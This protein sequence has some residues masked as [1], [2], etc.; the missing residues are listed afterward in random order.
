M[1]T[2][3]LILFQVMLLSILTFNCRLNAQINILPGPDVTP[4]DMVEC[5]VGD[6]IA[7]DNVTFQGA[8]ASRGIFTN[9][10]A[11][12]I[13]MESGIFLTSGA[14]YVIPGPNSSASAGAN[15][16][17]PGH[18]SL[19]A[20]TTAT[21]YDAAVLEF[22]FVPESDTLRFK[23]VFGSEEYNEWVFTQFNDVFG[24]FVS[25][26]D[27]M[28]GLYSDKN[29]AIVPGTPNTSVTINNVNNGYSPPGVVPIGPC[30]HCEYYSDNTNGISLEYDGF[31]VVLIAWVHVVA[32]ETYH[33]KIGVADAGDHIYDSGVFIEENSFESPKIEVEIE[34]IPQGVA[35]NMIEGCVEADIIFKLPNA[36]YAPITVYFEV[37]GSATNGVDYEE[38]PDHITFEEGEDTAYIHVIPFKDGIIEGEEDIVI[39]IENTLGCVVRYDTVEFIIIDYID[40]VTTPSPNTMICDG[41]EVEIWVTTENGIPP[42]TY[43]WFDLPFTTD[44]ITVSPDT[45]TTYVVNVMD[46]CLD[47]V[48]DSVLVTV[49]PSP[50]I[51]LGPDSVM[52]CMGDTLILNAG[53]GYLGYLWQ[54]GS[55]DSTYMV[56]QTGNYAVLVT[57]PGG[58]TGSDEIYVEVSE[59]YVN[60]GPDTTICIGDTLI[61]DAGSGYSSYLWQDNSTGQVYFATETGY[62]WVEV[63]NEDG[64]AAIDSLY[65]YVDDSVISLELGN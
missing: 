61:L 65:L 56:T 19:N 23:Y 55:E 30:T 35:E 45:T 3:N 27:P 62:Y 44:T 52:I 2:K 51:D 17:M 12:N 64:C 57:G 9:G 29:I 43:E 14:G 58:C 53:G 31:T 47:T 25:G 63:T 11:T 39:I 41:M 59:V 54:D 34:P 46:M 40:M 7:F 1:K 33:I 21:T 10:S 48:S 38:I 37:G 22:D 13:G 4:Y 20:I 6:G 26:P 60:L 16:G 24:Y 5:I 36:S 50:D 15:N 49:F 42:Y 18:A 28:G 8:A 32:C